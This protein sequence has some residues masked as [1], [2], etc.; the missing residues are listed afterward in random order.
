MAC[1]PAWHRPPCGPRPTGEASE[2]VGTQMT[3]DMDLERA[4]HDPDYRRQVI[5]RLNREAE[6]NAP[7]QAVDAGPEQKKDSR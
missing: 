2:P 4:I 7:P 5:E 1:S 6:D 3:E